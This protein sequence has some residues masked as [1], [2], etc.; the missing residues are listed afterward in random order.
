MDHYGGSAGS[1]MQEAVRLVRFVASP[2]R[3]PSEF[4]ILFNRAQKR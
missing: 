2:A 3:R 4:L 1:F